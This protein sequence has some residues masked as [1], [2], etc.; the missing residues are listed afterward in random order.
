MHARMSEDHPEAHE[1]EKQELTIGDK[2]KT[3]K[4]KKQANNSIHTYPILFTGVGMCF[5]SPVPMSEPS[6]EIS[7][8]LVEEILA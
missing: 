1:K 4:K 8:G 6:V 5:E 2:R 7:V 3:K